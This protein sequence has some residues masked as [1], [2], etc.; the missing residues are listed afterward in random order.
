ML[1]NPCPTSRR[2]QQH[3]SCVLCVGDCA[4]DSIQHHARC[5]RARTV[6]A[7]VFRRYDSARVRPASSSRSA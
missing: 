6:A 7:E 3:G 1:C 4:L 5:L 2:A